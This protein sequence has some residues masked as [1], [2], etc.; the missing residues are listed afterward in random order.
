MASGSRKSG[1]APFNNPFAEQARRLKKR[2]RRAMSKPPPR[3]AE[4]SVEEEIDPF[5]E[6]VRGAVPLAKGEG[7][8]PSRRR[9]ADAHLP[10]QR[11]FAQELDEHP[12]D[13][14]F[15]EGFIR[16][17]A[18]GV[19]RQTIARLERGEFAVQDHVDLHGMV[20]ED[21]R[22]CVDEF[23]QI[24]HR[25][26]RRCVLVITGK[27]RNSPGQVGVLHDQI[28][29]WLARGPSARLVLAFSTARDCDGGIGALYV[30]LRRHGSRKNRIDVEEGAGD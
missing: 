16:G 20:L 9:R 2:L 1:G 3:E 17:R 11:S 7:R 23:L 4:H 10:P 19:S 8:V 13:L 28:P 18:Y 24:A 25:R 27:G 26:G 15:S 12:F 6:A 5:D 30:L 21:A 22:A 14:R 29:K